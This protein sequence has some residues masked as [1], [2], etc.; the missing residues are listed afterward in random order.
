MKL[1]IITHPSPLYPPFPEF[2][3]GGKEVGKQEPQGKPPVAPVFRM[4]SA[5]MFMGD[6]NNLSSE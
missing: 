4:G 6:V 3:E 5:H 2:W 1:Y